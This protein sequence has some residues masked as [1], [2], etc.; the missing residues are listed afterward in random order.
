VPPIRIERTTNDLGKRCHHPTPLRHSGHVY[1]SRRLMPSSFAS[2]TTL[3]L[4]DSRSTAIFR[5]A[6]G[7]FPTRFFATCQACQFTVS[8]SRGSAHTGRRKIDATYLAQ[9]KMRQNCQLLKP[10]LHWSGEKNSAAWWWET[11]RSE[12]PLRCWDHTTRQS[13][14][15]QQGKLH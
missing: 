8:Q 7:N 2:A 13:S 10:S 11:F 15:F 9:E 3:S 14:C 12:L 4:C 5:N 6:F 1:N